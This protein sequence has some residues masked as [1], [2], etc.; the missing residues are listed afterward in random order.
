MGRNS[1]VKKL[2]LASRSIIDGVIR[3]HGYLDVDKIVEE[4]GAQ[5]IDLA[6]S[7]LH[8]Y[9]VGLRERDSLCAQPLEDT[10]ITIVERST[11]VVR[12]IKTAA[13]ADALVALIEAKTKI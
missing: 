12:V 2:D 9:L 8:R 3:S 1:A 4:L 7:T 13:T 11:G 5:G 10:V 6:R